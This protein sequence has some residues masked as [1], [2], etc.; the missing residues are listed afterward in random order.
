MTPLEVIKCYSF[1]TNQYVQVCIFSLK[2]DNISWTK[3][4]RNNPQKND[5]HLDEVM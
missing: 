3:W 5:N 4:D 1:K 2:I